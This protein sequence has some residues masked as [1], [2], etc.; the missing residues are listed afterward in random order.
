MDWWYL[1]PVALTTRLSGPGL[2][3]VFGLATLGVAG[4][5]WWLARRRPRAVFQAKVDIS[6]CFACTQC[7]QDCPFGAI[8]MVPR[9]DGKPFPSQAQVD[10]D[11]CIGCGVCTGACDTQGVGVGWFDGQRVTRELEAFV[12]SAVALGEKP[13]LALV[14]AQNHGGWELFDEAAWRRRLP[15]YTVRPIPCAGW[16]EPKVLERVITKGA[17]AVLVIGCSSGESYCRE[18]NLFLAARLAGT[19]GPEFRPNRADPR[20]VALA[21][22]DPLRPHLVTAAAARLLE[23]DYQPPARSPNRWLAGFA[24]ALLT[25]VIGAATLLP[26]DLRFRSPVPDAP[27]FVF[28]FRAHGAW[29]DSA[30]AAQ[31]AQDNRPVHMRSAQPVK[32]GRAPVRIT[33]TLDG[34]TQEH[35]IAPKGLQ[36]DG[37]SAGEL[38]LPLAPG[39][40]RIEVAVSGDARR[41]WTET[42]TAANGRYH[43]LAYDSARGFEWNP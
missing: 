2:W 20:R 32:R 13:A 41:T 42:V 39:A 16:V 38:R 33:L 25:V 7:S 37:V 6:R 22:F 4:V 17:R 24:A 15:G 27:V 35:L 3:L 23:R 5:P 29:L 26:S 30:Q 12:T 11:R 14:C 1:W 10:P 36:S 21:N 18:G 19:R 31:T 8:T 28:T 43:V 40:H 9:T 34:I